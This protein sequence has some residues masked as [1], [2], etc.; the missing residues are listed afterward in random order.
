MQSEKDK[1]QEIFSSFDKNGDGTI[2]KSEV[3]QVAKELGQE[4]S[5]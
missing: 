2:D 3:A 1:I 4:L 5:Q